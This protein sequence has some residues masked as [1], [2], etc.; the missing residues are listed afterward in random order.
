VSNRHRP[1]QQSQQRSPIIRPNWPES[2]GQASG[3]RHQQWL[4][5]LGRICQ[6]CAQDKDATWPGGKRRCYAI[7]KCCREILS[8]GTRTD[9]RNVLRAALP[10]AVEEQI[11][12]RNPAA[13]RLASRREPKRKHRSWTV[14]QARQFLESARRDGDSLY[15]AY[16]PH[17]GPGPAQRRTARAHLGDGQPRRQGTVGGRTSCR[18]RRQALTSS[19][20]SLI[21]PPC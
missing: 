6:C 4:N 19:I 21:C 13:F 2:A 14:D 11:I 8:P 16:V 15:P 10:Y 18:Q 3:Q 9:A 17:P 7:G 20:C 12:T 5:K 1:Q